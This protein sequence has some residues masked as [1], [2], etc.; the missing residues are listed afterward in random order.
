ML[1]SQDVWLLV[2]ELLLAM[3]KDKGRRDHKRKRREQPGKVLKYAALGKTSK[4][5][6]AL[7]AS[8]AADLELF[9]AEGHTALHLAA[10]H[11]H[12]QALQ[13]LLR[14]RHCNHAQRFWSLASEMS[15]PRRAGAACKAEDFKGNTP[16]HLAAQHGHTAALVALLEVRRAALSSAGA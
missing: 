12:T 10:L 16:A 11:G 2:L 1:L 9:N 14:C 6:R 8:P 3:P 15:R 7:D 13:T 4:L 5:A